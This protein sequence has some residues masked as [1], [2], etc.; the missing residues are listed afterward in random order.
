MRQITTLL[1]PDSGEII[2]NGNNICKNEEEYR[3]VLGYLPQDFGVYKNFTAKQFLNYMAVLKGM[4]KKEGK[5]KTEELLKLVGLHNVKDK[6]LGKF[7]GGMKRRCGIAQALLNDPEILILDEPTAG[8][9]PQERTRFRNLISEISKEKIVILSTHIISDIES[10]AKETIIMKD[11]TL[12]ISGSH[13]EI[14][15]AMNG[16]VYKVKTKDENEVHK[17]QSKYKVVNLQRGMDYTEIRI[18]SHSRPEGLNL[19]AIEPNFEDVYMFYFD[20]QDAKEV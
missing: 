20:L 9:D 19:E 5:A 8:L 11:G 7:S 2:Y 6:A 18:I 16:K 3:A 12:L 4:S 17:I 13:K 15:Q 1:K 10:I 14:L